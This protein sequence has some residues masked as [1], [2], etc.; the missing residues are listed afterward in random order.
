MSARPF[1]VVA[2]VDRDLGIGKRGA[3]PWRLPADIRHFKRLTQAT[4][5]PG[6][7]N[8]VIMG[9]VTWDSIPAKFRPLAGRLN[10]VLTRA[11]DLALPEG[12]MRAS[13]FDA[14]LHALDERADIERVFVIGGTQVYQTALA[15]PRCGDLYL[16]RIDASFACD[17]MLPDPRAHHEL[18]EER[19]RGVDNGLAYRIERWRRRDPREVSAS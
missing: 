6:L 7:R 12:V 1:V 18:A 15:H 14:A 3:I 11:G 10:V 19:E 2:A 5:T 16:T 4:S 9:R 8:A 13:D 17:R